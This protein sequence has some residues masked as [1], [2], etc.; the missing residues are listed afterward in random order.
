MFLTVKSNKYTQIRVVHSKDPTQFEEL[1]NQ[2]QVELQ[3]MKPETTKMEFTPDGIVAIIQFE[4]EENHPENAQDEMH[5]QGVHFTCNECPKFNPALNNDGTVRR[6][7]KKGKCF[8]QDIAFGD[9]PVC[10]WFCKQFLKGEITPV[11]GAK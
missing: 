11:G 8:L 5:L 9:A 7:S 6:S 2:A 3:S 4:K 1:L 10:E